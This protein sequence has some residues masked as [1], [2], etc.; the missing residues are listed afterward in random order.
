MEYFHGHRAGKPAG[1]VCAGRRFDEVR[2]VKKAKWLKLLRNLDVSAACAA[3]AVLVLNTLAAMVMRL[4]TE[5]PPIWPR[6]VQVFCQ[7]WLSFLGAGNRTAK[8]AALRWVKGEYAIW[9]WGGLVLC[10]LVIPFALNTANTP[11]FSTI[12]C[13]L[14]LIGGCI[15]RMLCVNSDDR[16]PLP[17]ENL[18]YKRIQT[19]DKRIFQNPTWET[20]A[21][22]TK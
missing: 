18:Y 22:I 21:T 12:A 6:E 14:V 8:R 1:S 9:F 7:V 4:V 13:V 17:G 2:S 3:L 10:G 19:D 20:G 11:L 15:L 5:Q 16:Q